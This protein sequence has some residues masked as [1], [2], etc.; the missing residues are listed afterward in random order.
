MHQWTVRAPPTQQAATNAEAVI[1]PLIVQT[2]AVARD[3]EDA[4]R[5]SDWE[6]LLLDRN[7]L[8]DDGHDMQ[9]SQ[10]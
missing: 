7:E 4:V 8:D 2:K 5:P 3:R 6:L 1:R 9:S 10:L